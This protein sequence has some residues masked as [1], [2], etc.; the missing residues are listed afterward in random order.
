MVIS[1]ADIT[2][3]IGTDGIPGYGIGLPEVLTELGRQEFK[4]VRRDELKV[5]A[6]T[7]EKPTDPLLA[8]IFGDIPAE[9]SELYE[10]CINYVDTHRPALCFDNF[11][12][13][14]SGQFLF[15]RQVCS[16]GLGVRLRR[17]AQHCVIFYFDHA[18]PLDL[19]DYWNLRAVGWEVMPLPKAV[20][21]SEKA[22]SVA[23]A[24]IADHAGRDTD[25]VQSERYVSIVKGRSISQEEH[26]A[27]VES[28]PESRARIMCQFLYPPMWDEFTHMSGRLDCAQFVA[29]TRTTVIGDDISALQIAALA[30][31]F[32]APGYRE[33]SAYANDLEISRYGLKEFG[34]AVIPP[35]EQTVARLFGFGLPDD[36]RIG[37][38]GL[39]F[40][41]RH[42]DWTVQLSQPTASDVVASVLKSKGWAEF[43][44]S[45]PGN[46]AYQMM[47]HLGG[48]YSINLLKRRRLIQYL[49]KLSRSGTWDLTPTFFAEIKKIAEDRS[50]PADVQRLVERYT[51]AKIF[52]LGLVVLCS[53]CT[54][55]SWYPLH[56]ADY[57]V[58]CPKMP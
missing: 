7:L 36:W 52:T 29:D 21:Q 28:L 34:T 57:Q 1:V 12:E 49:E 22:K 26:Q 23:R 53:V 46:I 45:P 56:V 5:L 6:P 20:A 10:R 48:P 43:K 44:I 27:L 35:D 15:R 47:R 4:F 50:I 55:R 14:H 18:D 51:D 19:V 41:G 16:Y 9:A 24:F 32:M 25:H 3:P 13:F 2:G 37:A 42:A 31:T 8:A 17:G 30:P 58:Q 54:Q 39:T 33:G 11:F 38:N 40:L